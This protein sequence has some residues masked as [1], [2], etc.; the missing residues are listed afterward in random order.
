MR[1]KIDLG[2]INS[3][4]GTPEIVAKCSEAGHTRYEINVGKCL[5][6]CGCFTCGYVYFIDSSD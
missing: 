5:T 3:W 2:Y 6:E 4:Q 1:G